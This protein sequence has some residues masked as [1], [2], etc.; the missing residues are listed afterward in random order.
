MLYAYFK[1][2]EAILKDVFETLKSK[3][4]VKAV[5]NDYDDYNDNGYKDYSD[6]SDKNSPY[7]DEDA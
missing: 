1:Q 5:R 6:Y 3:H 4:L 7:P 2:N